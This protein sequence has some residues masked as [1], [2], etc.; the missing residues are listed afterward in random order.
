MQLITTKARVFI[1][2]GSGTDMT[3]DFEPEDHISL[4]GD[5]ESAV[6]TLSSE[7]ENEEGT[8]TFQSVF[9]SE[10]P[11]AAEMEEGGVGGKEGVGMTIFSQTLLAENIEKGKAARK[12]ISE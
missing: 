2:V 4:L 9:L 3:S 5:D 11:E 8:V 1:A 12:Q 10:E 7:D 6:G